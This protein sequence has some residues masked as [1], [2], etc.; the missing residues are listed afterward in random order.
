[1]LAGVLVARHDAFITRPATQ[2][3][4][5]VPASNAPERMPAAAAP[6]AATAREE[7][8][9][10]IAA[11]TVPPPVPSNS[12]SNAVTQQEEDRRGPTAPG[13]AAKA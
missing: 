9:R 1:M 6:A 4:P 2:Q 7:A 8:E 10:V 11:W 3:R 5:A 12:N 13:P